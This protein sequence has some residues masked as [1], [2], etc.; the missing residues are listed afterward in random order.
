MYGKYM[1]VHEW[2][3][4]NSEISVQVFKLKW[5]QVID[6]KISDLKKKSLA[7]QSA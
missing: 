6:F 2:Y 3:F 5:K 1:V 7:A 4:M